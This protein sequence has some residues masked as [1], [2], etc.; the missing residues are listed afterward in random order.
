MKSSNQ[1]LKE[2]LMAVYE[3]FMEE[4]QIDRQTGVL[5][6]IKNSNYKDQVGLIRFS[7][8]P[9]VGSQYDSS[10]PKILVVGLDVGIDECCAKNTY[11][12][13]DSRNKSIEP[14][15]QSENKYNKHIAGT[16]GV[17]MFLLKDVYGWNQYWEDYFD[18]KTETFET[19]LKRFGPTVLPFDV[20]SHVAFTNIHKFVTIERCEHRSGVE[21]RKWYNPHEERDLFK[22]EIGYFAPDIV[23]IQ[24]KSK[25]DRDTLE[26]LKESGYRIVLSDHPSS[27]R[28]G[29][30]KPTYIEKL[31]Y[32][33]W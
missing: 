26:F 28:N 2:R 21:N 13:F 23:Y 4:L 3:Q 22:A 15:E 5:G 24:G 6:K 18:K 1:I 31:E 12:S 10:F 32:I 17:V 20:L 30:N 27:W 9:F 33:N 29:A 16:Y 25:F 14:T 19:I 8:Y 11:H 7:G